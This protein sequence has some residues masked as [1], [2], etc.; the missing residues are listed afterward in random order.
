MAVRK[1]H[2]FLLFYVVPL[3]DSNYSLSGLYLVMDTIELEL[4]NGIKSF[5]NVCYMLTLIGMTFERKK[6]AHL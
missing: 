2:Y 1:I 4:S 6:N 3:I 5:D